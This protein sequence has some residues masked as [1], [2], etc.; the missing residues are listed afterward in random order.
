MLVLGLKSTPFNH[1]AVVEFEGQIGSR[2]RAGDYVKLL[3]S[4]EE[5]DRVKSVVLDIDSPGGSATASNYLHLAVQSLAKRK[6]VVAFIRG[7]G[8]SGA[9]L[10]A[11]PAARIIAIPG[12][13]VGS[14][15]VIA[16]HPLVHEALDRVGVRMETTKSHELKDIGS[17]FREPTPEEREKE[18][19]LVDDLY[20]QFVASVAEGRHMT[21]AQ[22]RAAATG[23]V[24]TGRKAKDLGLIDELGDLDRALD[25][26][27]ELGSVT[28]HPVW[29]KPRRS[30][31]DLMPSSI[32]TALVGEIAAAVEERL[33]ARYLFQYRP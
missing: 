19:E 8:A 14:I 15:G 3:R 4:I 25:L 13:L 20:G 18:Q 28:R 17:P 23:E 5:N 10:F 26:A 1:I 31:R 2:I 7:V 30:L 11:A 27:A 21:E 22:V 9:Y 29:M 33:S 16:M 6:P 12:S 32:A 24:F